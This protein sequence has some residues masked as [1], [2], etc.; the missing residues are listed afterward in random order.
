LLKVSRK[1]RR[2][3]DQNHQQQ[4]KRVI[5]EQH[6]PQNPQQITTQRVKIHAQPRV[7]DTGLQTDLPQQII[8]LPL[9]LM[10]QQKGGPSAAEQRKMCWQKERETNVERRF[11]YENKFRQ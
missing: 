2:H 4:Q 11:Q 5:K 1:C 9:T 3:R 6:H 7:V 10:R 8:N